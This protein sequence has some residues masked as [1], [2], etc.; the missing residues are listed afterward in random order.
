MNNPDNPPAF[1]T[2]WSTELK[3]G[4]AIQKGQFTAQFPGMTL[5]DWFAG[6]AVNALIAGH[7]ASHPDHHIGEDDGLHIAVG[8]YRIAD[9]MLAERKRGHE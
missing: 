9:A 1:P 8:A 7:V 3:P 4:E 6:Q 2:E 5:R